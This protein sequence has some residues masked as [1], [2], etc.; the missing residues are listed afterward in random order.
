MR[1]GPLAPPLRVLVVAATPYFADRGCHV[2][3]QGQAR[4]L[5]ARGVEVTIVTYAIGRDVPGGALRRARGLPGYTRLDAA[6]SLMKPLLDLFVLAETLRAA[7]E[8]RPHVIHAHTQEGGLIGLLVGRMLGLPVVLDLQS[9]RVAEELVAY[10][11]S[12]E[13]GWLYRFADV[14]DRLLPRSADAVLASTGEIARWVREHAAPRGQVAVVGD[15]IELA[16]ERAPGD[17]ALARSLGLDPDRPVIVY[18]GLLSE[19]QGVDL[20]LQAARC[21]ADRR[22]PVQLLVMGYPDETRWSERARALGLA[23]SV[24]FPGRIPFDQASAHLALGSLAVSAKRTSTEGNGKLLSYIACGLPVL[25]LDTAVNREILGA[26]G[27]YAPDHAE[28]FALA[29]E[30]ALARPADSRARGARLRERARSAYSWDARA[31]QLID[32]YGR[33]L[34]RAGAER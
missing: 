7:L 6:P 16:S 10:G 30:S 5:E 1:P 23:G 18:L 25:A 8:L 21:L 26:D 31:A 28:A 19:L 15:A 12:P 33:L 11:A 34:G 20:L 29:I 13:G 22:S 14:F 3:I 2:R 24:F 9:R 17:P 4:A 27:L 32:I